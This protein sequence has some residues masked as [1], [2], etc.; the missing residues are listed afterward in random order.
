MFVV[1]V[2]I[3]MNVVMVMLHKA[4]NSFVSYENVL[5]NLRTVYNVQRD[6]RIYEL[7][8]GLEIV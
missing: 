7:G 6:F 5:F 2:F 4:G 3:Y 1:V 8:K